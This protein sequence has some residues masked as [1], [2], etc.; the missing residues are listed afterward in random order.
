MRLQIVA[1]VDEV[2]LG[3]S[4]PDQIL[5]LT[6]FLCEL[7][8]HLFDLSIEAFDS[9]LAFVKLFLFSLDCLALCP[10]L[11]LL[12]LDFLLFALRML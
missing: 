11:L 6:L 5:L 1:F 2:C 4:T 3:G 12:T 10:E 8:L 9:L 7:S